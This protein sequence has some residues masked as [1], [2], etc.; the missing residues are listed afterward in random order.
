MKVTLEED[1]IVS[2]SGETE[3]GNLPK[4]VGLE[5][6]RWTGEQIVDLMYHSPLW[7]R[8]AK[9]VFTLHS[10]AVSGSQ[11]VDMTWA[12]R[13]RL[14]IE[15]GA[16]RLRTAIEMTEVEEVENERIEEHHRLLSELKDLVDNL[17]YAQIDAHIDN[18][19]GTLNATQKNS[20]K[21]LYKSVLFLAKKEAMV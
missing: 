12:A 16:I 17:S 18:V 15:A 7:V 3:V 19:F 9:G 10:V 4:G 6:L 11:Q 5:R 2:L 1:R 8:Y 14:I 21:R 13:K 20:L